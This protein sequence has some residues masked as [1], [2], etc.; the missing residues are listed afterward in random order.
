[1]S[2]SSARR[3]DI[4]ADVPLITTARTLAPQPK[5]LDGSAVHSP[6]AK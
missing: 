3:Q 5:K 1:M 4:S 6:P 2:S